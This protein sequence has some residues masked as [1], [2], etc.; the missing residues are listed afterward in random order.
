MGDAAGENG[1]LARARAG[2]NQDGTVDVLDGLPLALVRPL[3]DARAV[4]FDA[5]TCRITE[6]VVNPAVRNLA[7]GELGERYG[8]GCDSRCF[9][10]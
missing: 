10:S 5:I 2:D 7:S 4:D 9:G 8:G 3:A 1:G 6:E